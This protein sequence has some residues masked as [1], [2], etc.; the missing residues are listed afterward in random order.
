VTGSFNT[1]FQYILDQIDSASDEV[2]ETIR[3]AEAK[4]GTTERQSQRSERDE[5]QKYRLE[6]MIHHKER[7]K[8]EADQ[9][10]QK[11]LELQSES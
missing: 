5:A 2:N 1:E 10:A 8:A 11:Q 4:L 3:L 9:S 6:T 7:L